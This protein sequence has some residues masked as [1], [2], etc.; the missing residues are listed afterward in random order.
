MWCGYSSHQLVFG[1]NP[2]LPNI[3]TDNIAA[4]DGS[5]SSKTFAEHLNYLHECRRAFIACE[6]D[7]RIRRALRNKVRAAEEVYHHGDKV[8]YK[9][10]KS[11]KWIGPAKTIYQDGKVV[12]VRHGGAFVKVSPTRLR[13]AGVYF[14]SD[15]EVVKESG[16]CAAVKESVV[17]ENV[18]GSDSDDEQDTHEDPVREIDDV[19]ENQAFV[20]GDQAANELQP[21]RRSLRQ[22]NKQTGFPVYPVY[23]TTIPKSQQNTTECQAAKDVELQKLRDFDVYDEAAYEHQ[24][25]VSTRWVL[26]LKGSEVR[27]RL[28]ARGFEESIAMEKD[29]PTVGKLAVRLFLT[30][31]A[32]RGWVVKTTD[33]KS[34]FLQGNPLDRDVFLVPPKE[35]NVGSG[36]I[37]KLKRCLYG[38]NDAARKFYDSVVMELK[39]LGCK[40]S[41][42][43]PAL[44]YFKQ[45]TV[46]C[47]IVVSHIDDF[48]HAGNDVFDV[49]VMDKLRHRFVAGKLMEADFSYVGFGVK[50]DSNGIVIDQNKFVKRMTVPLGCDRMLNKS[51]E[52]SSKEYTQLRSIVGSMNWV[53]HG[54]RPDIS[55]DLIDLSMKFHKAKV[56]DL[57]RAVKIAR[58]LKEVDS[59]LKFPSLNGDIKTW[60]LAVYTDAAHGNL[61]DGTSST[62]SHVIFLVDDRNHCCTLA[63][64][65]N[66][67]KRVVRS[68]LA[69]EA[70]S[71]QEG[72]EEA[73]YLKAMLSELITVNVPIGAYIDNMSTIEAVRSTK[74]VDD[75]R[76]RID[77]AA[78]KQEVAQEVISSLSWV[79]DKD[80]LANCMTKKG[81][82][83]LKLLAVLHTGVLVLP[84]C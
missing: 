29:S 74:M 8:F 33:I 69:A 81:A 25:C 31:S 24:E 62:G 40:Q 41:D 57:T 4:L 83:N 23:I 26:W 71:L 55:F 68:T 20:Q 6:A 80:Q 9:R 10:E 56:E 36:V 15:G 34:A 11:E 22:Y 46:L 47:G 70:L 17:D 45:G 54:T 51:D 39:R 12:L 82:S 3:M 37:W 27:A 64:R 50:Q 72:I 52:L 35:A 7:E 16:T 42:S 61:S 38:L 13:K 67:I 49:S 19:V 60:K 21:S 32:S 73:V 2:N 1:V 44:F 43:D 14:G 48:L 28:V 63:W 58:K 53:A 18:S 76:L 79:A 66:K 65:S 77:I 30:L 5:T 59:F 84:D 75:R 78:I